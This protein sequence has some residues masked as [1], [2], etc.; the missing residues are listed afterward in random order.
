MM[1]HYLHLD[2]H[3]DRIQKAVLDTIAEGKVIS[4]FLLTIA[5]CVFCLVPHTRLRRLRYKFSI[6]GGHL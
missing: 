1:L 6:H 4:V 3:A 2:A 5:S